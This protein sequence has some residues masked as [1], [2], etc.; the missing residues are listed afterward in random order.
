M[1]KKS[2]RRNKKILGALAAGLGAMA[3]MRGRGTPAA[4]NVDSGRGSGLRET[5]D[6]GKNWITKKTEPAA[7]TGTEYPGSNKAKAV[8][9]TSKG[10]WKGYNH[11]LIQGNVKRKKAF[12]TK[13]TTPGMGTAVAPPSILNPY[14][15]PVRTHNRFNR[16]VNVSYAKG[17]KVKGCG[18]AKRGL[19]RAIKKGR[20]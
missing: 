1:S 12:E 10:D 11:P 19:G 18:I 20:K 9:D 2:R 4:A 14:K 16:G 6:S 17:G 15:A 13:M 8:V 7:V 5:V 3:L